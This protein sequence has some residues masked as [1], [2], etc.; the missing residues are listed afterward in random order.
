[1]SP[2]LS[3]NG[4]SWWSY[5]RNRSSARG[6]GGNRV[7]N[8]SYCP[9]GKKSG[10]RLYFSARRTHSLCFSNSRYWPRCG[11]NACKRC[12]ATSN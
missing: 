12:T 8:L 2:T 10:V 1:M 6:S 9:C 11:L 4:E 7:W 3:E 5:C